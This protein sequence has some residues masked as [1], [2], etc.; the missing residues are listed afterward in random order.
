MTVYGIT[1]KE[2]SVTFLSHDLTTLTTKG[3]ERHTCQKVTYFEARK[4]IEIDTLHD[5]VENFCHD[6]I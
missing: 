4:K 2:M 1:T 5:L 3:V 6:K